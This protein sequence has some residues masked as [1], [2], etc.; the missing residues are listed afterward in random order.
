[1]IARYSCGD[2]L[3]FLWLVGLVSGCC[4]WRDMCIIRLDGR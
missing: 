3:I 4:G 1:M 2:T